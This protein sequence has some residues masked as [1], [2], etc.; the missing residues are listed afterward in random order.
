MVDESLL[1]RHQLRIPRVSLVDVPDVVD[2]LGSAAVTE[3]GARGVLAAGEGQDERRYLAPFPGV[4]L[5]RARPR[6]RVVDVAKARVVGGERE[7]ISLDVVR[8]VPVMILELLHV[9][10]AAADRLLGIGRVADAEPLRR[11]RH[12]LEENRG[13]CPAFAARIEMALLV[14]LGGDEAPVE[15]VVLRMAAHQGVVGRE[16]P[17]LA[18]VELVPPRL[19]EAAILLEVLVAQE[20]E[21]GL[22]PQIA[23]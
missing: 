1:P 19:L 2:W 15:A 17:G 12:Q 7:A 11:R 10:E 21:V 13:A 8:D 16:R 18:R 22:A 20:V 14:D 9:L 6:A 4:L 5:L 23:E 3:P